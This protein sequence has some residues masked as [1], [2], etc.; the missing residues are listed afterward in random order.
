MKTLHRTGLVALFATF[1]AAVQVGLAPMAH[2]ADAAATAPSAGC[3]VL[4][5]QGVRPGQGQLMI[6]VFGSA[7]SF[8][9]KPL[10]SLRVPAG[11]EA[12]QRVTAC[13]LDA[14]TE[15]A[16]MMFQDLNGDGQ[17]ARNAL[18]VPSEPWG[19]SG[20]PGMFGPSWDTGRVALNGA[21]VA[22]QLSK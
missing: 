7:E 10:A 2:A 6:N 9:K 16:V 15:I 19:S 21:P 1:T 22:V 3:A 5:L 11:A 13:G 17:M 4:E 14:A 8:G 20:K 18:G 12:T